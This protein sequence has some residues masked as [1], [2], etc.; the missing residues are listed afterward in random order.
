MGEVVNLKAPAK[1]GSGSRTRPSSKRSA[2][3]RTSKR[4]GQRRDK[5]ALVLG[6]GGFTGGVYEIGALRALDLLAANRTIN[7]F[8]VYV[9][10]SAGAFVASLCANGVTPEEMMRVV[11]HQGPQAFRD[12]DLGDL[13]RLNLPELAR[14]GVRLPL[15]VASLARQLLPQLGQVSLID[16]LL[17][18]AEALPSGAYTGQ[19][20][21]RYMRRV[22]EENGRHDDFRE[23]EHE[24]YLVATDLDTCERIVFGAD[25]FDDVPI[26][27][28]VRASG[29]LPMV[30]A[31]VRVGDR[32]LIDGGIVSTTN[33]DIAVEA[34]ADLVIVINPIVPFVNERGEDGEPPAR[35]ISD[36]GFSK[37]GYQAFKLLG[38]RRLHEMA[39]MWEER[40]P[41]VDI[42]LI[43]PEPTDALMFETSI[44]SFS[45]R[46]DIARHGFQSVTYHLL[47]EYERY[48]E[49]WARHGIDISARRVRRVVDHFEAEEEHVG[50][51]RKI[52]EGTTGAL[53]RQSGSAG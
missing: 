40:Y 28:A 2:P 3:A 35:R 41:G 32:E 37:I 14:T 47:D 49:I 46:I 34:G 52:L 9:G 18:L 36:M 26:S 12:I 20:I 42:V 21:E 11:T 44:M 48:S 39:K 43:E 22:L 53:L 16:I 13:L 27:T 45:S 17:G 25:G 24:L 31:P 50:A 1:G 4:R 7:Q 51:W 6:G 38:H 15:R 30:Y 33:L 23:L 10:T 5:T 29:A 19:G 8:D